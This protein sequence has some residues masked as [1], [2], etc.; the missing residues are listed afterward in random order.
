MRTLAKRL[1]AFDTR[2]RTSGAVD[3]VALFGTIDTLRSHLS[4]LMGQGGF[5]A[6]L[7]RALVLA[8]AEIPWLNAVRV[9]ADGDL[10]GLAVAQTTSDANLS[11]G[12]VLLLAQLLS[13]LV[14]FIG[15]ALTL[16]VINQI[17]PQ[18]AFSAADF[19]T[20]ASHEEAN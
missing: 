6:L 11:E 16:R 12:E 3:D 1:K 8:S 15:I 18:L 10:E 19:D 2:T 4:M 20:T 9:G 17:W 14:A 5:Q 13:L 7:A